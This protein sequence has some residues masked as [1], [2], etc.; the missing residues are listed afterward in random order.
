MHRLMAT[1][2]LAASLFVGA[3]AAANLK[4][5]PASSKWVLDVNVRAL[6][7]SPAGQTVLDS[8]RG[9]DAESKLKAFEAMTSLDITKSIDA[10]TVCGAGSAE[11]GGVA[12]LRG[13]WDTA[14]L[15]TIL[16]GAKA[17]SSRAHGKYTVLSWVDEKAKEGKRTYACFAAPKLAL[18]ASRD[19]EIVAALETLD[20][21]A[22]NLATVPAFAAL[23][24]PGQVRFVQVLAVSMGE[25]AQP[26]AWM[27]KQADSFGLMIAPTAGNDLAVTAS[28]RALTPEAAEQMKNVLLGMQAMVQ[29]QGNQKPDLVALAAAARVVADGPELKLDLTLPSAMIKRLLA[30]EMAKSARAEA[31]ARTVPPVPPAFK[32]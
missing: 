12:Y 32:E 20:G 29:L 5:L 27:L 17:Y 4:D 13:T 15:T 18:M 14:K 10:I 9:T 24:R 26:Q 11:K 21:R 3:A 28:L 8:I 2:V 25:Y 16:A 6:L 7:D 23:N 22:P 31:A 19:S 30:D 1:A